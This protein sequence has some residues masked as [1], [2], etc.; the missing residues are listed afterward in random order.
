[1]VEP[2]F[3]LAEMPPQLQRAI[4]QKSQ[5]DR[6]LDFVNVL[7][8]QE[9]IRNVGLNAVGRIHCRMR[10]KIRPQ[11][12]RYKLMRIAGVS[13]DTPGD[14]ALPRANPTAVPRTIQE[15]YIADDL[16]RRTLAAGDLACAGTLF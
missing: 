12:A 16:Y 15:S 3:F 7:P 13:H 6:F 5:L 8:R 4:V 1:M 11:H 10:I 9:N 14:N 2:Q